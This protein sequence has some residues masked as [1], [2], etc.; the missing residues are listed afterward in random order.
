M[1]ELAFYLSWFKSYA[2]F[3][4]PTPK[5][6]ESGARARETRYSQILNSLPDNSPWMPVPTMGY[7]FVGNG[8]RYQAHIITK[9]YFLT[10]PNSRGGGNHPPP[11]DPC[12]YFYVADPRVK[13]TNFVFYL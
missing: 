3:T 9:I 7:V 1:K 11:A 8:T 2:N 4:K 12:Y 13:F 6:R 5:N 10:L